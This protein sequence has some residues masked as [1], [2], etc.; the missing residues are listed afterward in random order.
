MFPGRHALRLG[1]RSC[2]RVIDFASSTD[3]LLDSASPDGGLL[4][5]DSPA[6]GLLASDSPVGGLL[7]SA[8]PVG[9]AVGLTV[10]EDVASLTSF[11]ANSAV[12]TGLV[13][14]SVPS[15]LI[16]FGIIG[17]NPPNPC[18]VPEDLPAKPCSERAC[19]GGGPV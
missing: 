1:L 8:S 18:R 9:W 14:L 13:A 6:G 10:D 7:V 19:A 2:L 3:G 12:A 4:A 5:S 16:G 11:D 15:V 17:T